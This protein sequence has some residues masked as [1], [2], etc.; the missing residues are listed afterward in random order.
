MV[1]L[2]DWYVSNVCT[3]NQILISDFR[4]NISYEVDLP[5]MY[6]CDLSKAIF[7]DGI[8]AVSAIV[9]EMDLIVGVPGLLKGL[10]I[11]DWV[12]GYFTAKD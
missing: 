12:S 4:L 10:I 11:I 6:Y 3:S 1:L 5:W 2:R 9:L 8:L 7:A